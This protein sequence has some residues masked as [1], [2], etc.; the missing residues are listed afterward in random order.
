MFEVQQSVKNQIVYLLT[1]Q[2]FQTET[3]PFVLC[4]YFQQSMH[5]ES[6]PK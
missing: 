2:G 1:I 5:V 6:Y 4:K 3:Q